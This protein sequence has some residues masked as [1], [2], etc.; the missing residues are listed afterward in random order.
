MQLGAPVP[1]SAASRIS[2]ISA[3]P[4]GCACCE[5]GALKAK[6]SSA[7]RRSDRT[8][9]V[10]RTRGRG[11]LD[12]DARKLA[13]R[14]AMMRWLGNAPHKMLVDMRIAVLFKWEA[15]VPGMMQ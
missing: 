1:I 10:P 5:L 3:P 7:A 8:S 15:S 13:R 9:S 4:R 6:L 12:A 11:G 2:L 14:L